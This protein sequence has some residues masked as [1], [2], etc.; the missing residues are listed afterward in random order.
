MSDWDDDDDDDDYFSE[1]DV[2]LTGNEPKF[3]KIGSMDTTPVVLASL[4]R[5]SVV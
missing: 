5:K 1:T 3:I 2:D 4:D